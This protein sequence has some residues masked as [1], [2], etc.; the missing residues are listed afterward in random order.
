MLRRILSDVVVGAYSVLEREYLNRVER[1]HRLPTGSRQR[2]VRSGRAA[3]YRDI[4]YVAENTV[5][6][7]DG[8]L[9]HELARDRWDDLDRDVPRRSTAR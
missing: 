4:E 9:G 2:R 8:R 3:A 7:L 1:P 6:E 5:V